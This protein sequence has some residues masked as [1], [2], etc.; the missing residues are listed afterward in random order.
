MITDANARE[1]HTIEFL[2]GLDAQLIEGQ[3]TLK[4]R[5]GTISNGWRDY[6]MLVTTA[7]R[8]LDRIYD[9]LPDKTLRHMQRLCQY[10]QII[11][12]PRPAVK[13]GDDVQIVGTD[14][15]R[16]V[17]NSCVENECGI[18]VKDRAGQK[19]CKL[20]KALMNIAPTAAL[21]KDGSCA[22]LDVVAGNELGK[23]I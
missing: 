11:I 10:G 13:L 20:R 14:D 4:E 7:E 6:R 8:L 23:Y 22:Y 3:D 12:R 21:H 17:I 1:I 2:A 16:A 18:C 9:T 19:G 15:L 5:L